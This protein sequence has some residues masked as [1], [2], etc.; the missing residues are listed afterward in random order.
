LLQDGG[1]LKFHVPGP[2]GAVVGRRHWQKALV[3]LDGVRPAGRL[4]VAARP[5]RSPV[6]QQHE[7]KYDGRKSGR[8]QERVTFGAQRRE[9]PV[10][11][12]N[13]AAGSDA[14]RAAVHRRAHHGLLVVLGE[15]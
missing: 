14:A 11:R 5:A 1:G 15:L 7:Q 9:Q 10:G 3:R 12:A 6:R 4:L 13:S 8:Q 2:V